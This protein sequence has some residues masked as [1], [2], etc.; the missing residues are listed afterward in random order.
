MRG[1]VS[2]WKPPGSYEECV[3]DIETALREIDYAQV[4]TDDRITFVRLAVEWH[5]RRMLECGRFDL[6]VRLRQYGERT[7]EALAR[8]AP[9][10]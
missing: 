3:A 6:A 5:T 1:H 4:T 9:D 8:A 2:G 10:E 7:I